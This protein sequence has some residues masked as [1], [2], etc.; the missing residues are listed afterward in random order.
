MITKKDGMTVFV[1]IYLCLLT[2][3]TGLYLTA[4]R[5]SLKQSVTVL[6]GF[7]DGSTTTLGNSHTKFYV[8]N[9]NGTIITTYSIVTF[10]SDGQVFSKVIVKDTFRFPFLFEAREWEEIYIDNPETLY[11]NLVDSTKSYLRRN[12]RIGLWSANLLMFLYFVYKTRRQ[13]G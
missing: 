6:Q 13:Q 10:V 9:R 3:S 5:F 1:V 4:E 12:I 2:L 11:T 7:I 8:V